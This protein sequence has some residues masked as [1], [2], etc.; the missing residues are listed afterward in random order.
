MFEHFS[1]LYMEEL[2][3]FIS[4]L[5]NFYAGKEKVFVEKIKLLNSIE[6]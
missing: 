3:F 1:T 6:D 4:L 5:K 2:M